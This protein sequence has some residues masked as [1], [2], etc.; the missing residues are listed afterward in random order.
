MSGFMPPTEPPGDPNQPPRD[1]TPSRPSSA[2]GSPP[3]P[4]P[5]PPA[6]VYAA[7]VERKRRGRGVLILLL[8][9]CVLG[10]L[11]S[12]MVNFALLA[13]IDIGVEMGMARETI[14]SG[15]AER[16]VAVL[17]VSGPI[18]PETV[19]LVHEFCDTVE[20]DG[21]VKAILL[22]VDSPGGG[23]SS[24]DQIYHRLH[25]MLKNKNKKMV[26]SMG[27]VAASGGYYI[28]APA[29]AIVAEPTT[30]TGSIGVISV[31][32]VLAGTFEKLGMNMVVVR[33]SQSRAWKAAPNY[34]EEPAGG[35]EADARG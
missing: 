6:P 7:P 5:P 34:L 8:I 30:V 12:V 33:S 4:P 22:R 27:S 24:C 21:N 35:E 18:Y 25:A 13:Q 10:L 20:N 15:P 16:T 17:D 29:D 2:A 26:V 3:P 14:R 31:F 19:K 28:S 23:I 9:F 11:G 1:A 32:P